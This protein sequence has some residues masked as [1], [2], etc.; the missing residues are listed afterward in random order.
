V[1]PFRI[2]ELTPRAFAQP[3]WLERFASVRT[4]RT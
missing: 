3:D 1:N 2:Y 4:R